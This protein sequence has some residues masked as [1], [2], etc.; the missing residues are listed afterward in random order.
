MEPTEDVPCR[1]IAILVGANQFLVK[2][3]T[4]TTF[5]HTH[6]MQVTELS[7]SPN[8]RVVV[9]VKNLAICLGR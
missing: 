2:I 9:E 1:N 5:Q 3:G 4:I 8:I 6:H 7:I